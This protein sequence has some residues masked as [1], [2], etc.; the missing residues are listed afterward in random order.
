MKSRE[1][2][3]RCF[4]DPVRILKMYFQPNYKKGFES[5]FFSCIA[6][7]VRDMVGQLLEIHVRLKAN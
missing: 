1:L 7:R 5:Y 6:V 2:N 4:G 3:L